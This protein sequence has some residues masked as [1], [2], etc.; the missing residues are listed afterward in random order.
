METKVKLGKIAV[1]IAVTHLARVSQ[2]ALRYRLEDVA[3]QVC[4]RVFLL[5]HHEQAVYL[6]FLCE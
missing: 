4:V 6:M 1:L 5:V 3:A 2:I